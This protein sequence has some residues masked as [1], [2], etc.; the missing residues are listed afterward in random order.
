MLWAA[1]HRG[2]LAAGAVLAASA[3][4]AVAKSRDR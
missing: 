1:L 3:L 4:M 2:W